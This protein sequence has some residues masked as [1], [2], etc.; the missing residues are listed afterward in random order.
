MVPMIARARTL[1]L[2][3]VLATAGLG[4]YASIPASANGS[5]TWHVQAGNADDPT[6]TSLAHEVTAF[7]NARTVVHPGDDILFTPIGDHSVTFNPIRIPGVPDFAYEDPNFP[8]GPTGNTLRFANRPGGALLTSGGFSSPPPPG[9]PPPPPGSPPPPPTFTLHIGADAAGPGVDSRA[10][11]S[12]GDGESKGTTY[13]F[14]C[15]FHREMAG[16]ITVLPAGSQLPSTDAKNQ[17]RAQKA[18]AADLARGS[19]ALARA[20]RNAEDN[21]VAAGLGVTSVQGLGTDSILRFAPA[22]IEINTGDSVTWTNQDINAPH[23]VTFG[24]ELPGPPGAPPGFLPYGG[25]S[26][27]STSDHVNS[28]FLIYQELI[29][30]LNVSSLIPPPPA[31]VV[32]HQATFTFTKAG[33]YP[34]F[35]ALHDVV[36]MVGTIIVRAED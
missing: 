17:I 12:S 6:F 15:M 23:T 21:R 28:G 33:T 5:V 8:I 36:G 7:Y 13:K 2:S 19:R 27:S 11:Q 26:I 14:F 35:C 32:T 25:S 22:T 34:Y 1:G 24:T 9:S 29:D 16:K 18:M 10:R 4:G 31:F 30:Y 3:I 20:S